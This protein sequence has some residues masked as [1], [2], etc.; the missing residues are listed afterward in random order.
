MKLSVLT[1][2]AIFI[3]AG[4]LA[5]ALGRP[6][7][8]A[9]G[10]EAVDSNG[11]TAREEAEGKVIW[12]KIQNKEAACADFSAD[13][14][15]ALGEYFMGRMLGVSHEAMNNLMT[16]MMGEAGEKEMHVVM[17][18][19]FSGCD[20]SAAF[21]GEARSFMP[22]MQMMSSGMMGDWSSPTGFKPTKNSMMGNGFGNMMGYG[23]GGLGL[24]SWITTLLVWAALV[25]VI[26][27]LWRWIQRH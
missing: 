27:A 1:L 8:L 25:L 18:K 19:R 2:F 9:R 7:G 20:S 23:W 21:S 4:A 6:A 3:L 13:D 14:F 10:D 16:R 22:M 11:H 17:G 24:V 15:A 12:E 26:V 5:L